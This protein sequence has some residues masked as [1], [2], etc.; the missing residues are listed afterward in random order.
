MADHAELEQARGDVFLDAR[1][2]GRAMRLSW[3]PEADVVVLSLW[4]EDT[5]AGTFR[6][7]HEDVGAF[8]D[9]LV[10]NL[11]D[12]PGVHLPPPLSSTAAPV[13]P[14]ALDETRAM[15][16]HEVKVGFTDW[17]FG[18]TDVNGHANAS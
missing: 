13:D 5:C 8:I 9:A 7:P 3:H 12:A 16:A 15:T 17:A 2:H 18:S 4:R 6:M 11:R 10:D 1:G 14:D